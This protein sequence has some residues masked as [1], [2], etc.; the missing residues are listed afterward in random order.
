MQAS[1]RRGV[2]RKLST[3]ARQPVIGIVAEPQYRPPREP[4]ALVA[5]LHA[6]GYAPV[7]LDPDNTADAP[8]AKLDLIVARGR[9]P[10]LLSLLARAEGKGVRTINR[11]AAIA[12]ARA[13]ADM[14]RALAQAGFETPFTFRGTLASIADAFAANQYP[15]IIKPVYDD[16]PCA[17]RVVRSREELLSLEW[18][19]PLAVG[20]SVVAGKGVE[21]KLYVAGSEV[22]AA[23]VPS[24]LSAGAIPE[25]EPV[26]LSDSLKSLA[27]R[28]GA[29]F[30]LEIFGVTC[31]LE[32]DTPVVMGVNAFPDTVG[33]PG[34][35]EM[36][37]RFV[38]E[39]AHAQVAARGG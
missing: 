13:K 5:A 17:P 19:H 37:A 11:C 7:I 15:V 22:L 36:V 28:C 6:A 2:R 9:S 3:P 27:F 35:S 24:P 10:T 26:V 31:V 29:L 18:P 30:G 33:I 20:Q 32:G 8:L 14:S 34:A 39:R 12:G 4:A 23:T 21:L 25:P 1:K 16:E 38:I